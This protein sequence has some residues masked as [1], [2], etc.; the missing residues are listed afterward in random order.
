[1]FKSLS[2]KKKS[3]TANSFKLDDCLLNSTMASTNTA[4][5]KT[6]WTEKRQTNAAIKKRLCSY[7]Q[8][9]KYFYSNGDDHSLSNKCKCES[10]SV[11]YSIKSKKMFKKTTNKNGLETRK[12]FKSKAFYSNSKKENT[13]TEQSFCYNQENIICSHSNKFIQFGQLQIW[14]I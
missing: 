8:V 3:F 6:I 2:Y 9:K 14:F 12:A 5:N 13:I 10:E 1:M 4:T 7:C 11:R